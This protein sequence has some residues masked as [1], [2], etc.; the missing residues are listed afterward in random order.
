M[1]LA[2]TASLPKVANLPTSDNPTVIE[3]GDVFRALVAIGVCVLVALF[4]AL[5]LRIMLTPVPPPRTTYLPMRHLRWVLLGF[6]LLAVSALGTELGQLGRT[7]TWRLVVNV[8]GVSIGLI[9][10]GRLL[11]SLRRTNQGS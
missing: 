8:L 11:R 2:L 6:A 7:V 9:G 10:T 1:I 5:V 3:V 4:A